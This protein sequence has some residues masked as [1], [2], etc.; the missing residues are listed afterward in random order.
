M[1]Y[2]SQYGQDKFINET[3]FKNR[4]SGVF[5]DI[6]A[7]DGIDG[8]NSY[9]FETELD[10]SGVCIEPLPEIFNKLKNNRKCVSINGCAWNKNDTKTFRMISG[11][12]EMLSG[13]VDCYDDKHI[14][15]ITS[16]AKDR[17]E[18]IEDIIVKCFDI[19]EILKNNN[20]FNIDLL[21]IDVEGAEFDII[22]AIDFDKYD[23]KVIVA[24]NNYDDNKVRNLLASKGYDFEH[25]L[26][27]DDVFVKKTN[28]KIV[29]PS[30]NFEKW[31][32]TTV[33]SV[34]LQ[35]YKN[36]KVLFIDD[37][38][39]DNTKTIVKS[40]TENNDKWKMVYNKTN[41]RRIYN[42]NP[43]NEYYKDFIENDHDVVLF[44]DGDDW[45]AYDNVL[46][47]LHEFYIQNDPWMTYGS[48]LTYPDL[49]WPFPQNTECPIEIHNTN[50]YRKDIWRY[51]HLRTFRW[52]LYKQ[53]QE[54]D[55]IS[56]KTGKYFVTVDDLATSYPCLERCPANK[57]GLTNFVTYIYNGSEESRSAAVRDPNFEIEKEIRNRPAYS[58]LTSYI[59]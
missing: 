29:I 36:Y 59:N 30:W 15:R 55:L 17:K 41:K 56:D 50:A 47:K 3:Y 51:S 24:E 7:F 57:I 31:C 42:I 18:K 14:H 11:Y 28:F 46:Q 38:S 54:K 9:F 26:T 8:S 23:I 25:R 58:K 22:S 53:I 13:L 20:L 44:V 33:E 6:G 37:A 40:L 34:N 4:K 27:I 1:K 19:N 39:T 35:T 49:T 45:L 5:L 12:N 16:E 32:E 52:G 48:F 43:H 10:W 2:Y 21:S